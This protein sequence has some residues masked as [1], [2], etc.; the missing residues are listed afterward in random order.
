[1]TTSRF[2]RFILGTGLTGTDNGDDTLTIATSGAPPTGA[3]GGVLSGTY[4]NPGMAAG[5]AASNV[6]TVGGD[7]AGTLPNPTVVALETT[8]GPTRLAVGAIANGDYLTRSGSSII[9]GSPTPGGPPTG[10]AGGDLGSTYPNPTVVS[11][12]HIASA[13]TP[14]AALADPTTGKVIGSVSSAAAAVF[15]PGYEIAY[16]EIT[17][18]VNVTATTD[19]GTTIISPGAI[20]FDGTPV[21]LEFFTPEITLPNPTSSTNFLVVN[22]TESSAVVAVLSV[23][24]LVVGTAGQQI[25]TS[26]CAKLRFTPSA[27]SHTYTITSKVNSTTG[28]PNIVGGSGVS[29]NRAPAF[30]RFTKV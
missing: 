9:G 12:A 14:I 18:T 4:P 20:T 6:G 22:L 2:K 27:G 3:A 16:S 30:V 26:I 8:T 15:P 7:L 5:A 21:V 17:S 23:N 29:G 28:T 25:R 10:A 1:M 24:L 11:G 19:P 13:T